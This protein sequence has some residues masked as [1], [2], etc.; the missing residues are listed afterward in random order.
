M[1]T[2]EARVSPR[3]RR[4]GTLFDLCVVLGVI[5]LLIAILVPMVLTA[6]G[7]ASRFHCANNLREIGRAMFAYASENKG[8]LPST[9]PSSAGDSGLPDVSAS[10]AAAV[11]PFSADGPPHNSIPAALFLLVRTQG[12]SPAHFVCPGSDAAAD[13]RALASPRARSNF[14]DV[15]KHLAYSM[16]NP[17]GE[18]AMESG[19][20]WTRDLPADFVLVA[21]MNPGVQGI[22][23]NVLAVRS[24]CPTVQRLMSNSN[25]HNKQGQNV[26]CADGRVDFC[27]SALAGIGG[28]N[29][30]ITRNGTIHDAPQSPGDNILLPTD[31]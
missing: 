10:G 17:Y 26:L 9:R 25:N 27:S 3:R 20:E 1:T 14:T 7:R 23:D 30:Y 29:I 24:D 22:G 21:D 4:G 2:S 6:R 28:D 18:A 19:F 11:D 5:G 12:V 13:P 8:Q 15:K 31:D 16:Q